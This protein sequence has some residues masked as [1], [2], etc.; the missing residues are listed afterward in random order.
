M[1]RFVSVRRQHPK[2]LPRELQVL[3]PYFSRESEL[4]NGELGL[5]WLESAVGQLVEFYSRCLSPTQTHSW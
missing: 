5:L 1:T 4:K 2:L 3:S